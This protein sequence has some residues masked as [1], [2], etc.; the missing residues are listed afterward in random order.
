MKETKT[1]PL[2]L[3]NGIGYTTLLIIYLFSTAASFVIPY[4]DAGRG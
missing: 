1:V 3:T 4:A 2:A